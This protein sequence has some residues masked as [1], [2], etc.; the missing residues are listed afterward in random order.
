LDFYY[1]FKVTFHKHFIKYFTHS[2]LKTFYEW[3]TE[4]G[5]TG[6]K[7]EEGKSDTSEENDPYR[8][9]IESLVEGEISKLGAA[10]S[11]EVN[12]FHDL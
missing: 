12:I 5:N 7:P 6:A 1:F 8:T 2:N 11:D 3:L 9:H 10:G 4:W